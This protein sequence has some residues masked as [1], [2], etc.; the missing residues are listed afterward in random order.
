MI[1]RFEG[2]YPWFEAMVSNIPKKNPKIA[3][4]YLEE[5]EVITRMLHVLYQYH[6]FDLKTLPWNVSRTSEKKSW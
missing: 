1:F 3:D 4:E 2:E 6:K 5:T